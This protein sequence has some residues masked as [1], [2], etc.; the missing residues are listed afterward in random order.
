M[1][2]SAA[3]AVSRRQAHTLAV[4]YVHA[5]TSAVSDAGVPQTLVRPIAE[6]EARWDFWSTSDAFRQTLPA[7]YGYSF[8][9]I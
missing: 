9:L 3:S 2:R 8:V 4:K 5:P 6:H 7:A 1:I